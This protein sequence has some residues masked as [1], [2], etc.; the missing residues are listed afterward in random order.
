MVPCG[1]SLDQ[2]VFEILKQ[3]VLIAHLDI[4]FHKHVRIEQVLRTLDVIL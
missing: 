4:P 1:V 3:G 2:V